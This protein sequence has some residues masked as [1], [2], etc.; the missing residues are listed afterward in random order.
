MNDLNAQQIV[1]LTLLV[2][3]ITSIATGITTVSL[4]ERA[5]EPVVQTINRVIEKTVERVVESDEDGENPVERIV[6]TVVV[7]NE[8]LTIKAIQKNSGKL[9]RIY[10]QS[11]DLKTF[12]G[13]GIV[14]SESGDVVADARNI[15]SGLEYVGEFS[16]GSHSL[17]IKFREVNNPFA[18][19]SAND[20]A[21]FSSASFGNSDGVQLAQSVIALSGQ[22][23]N[24]VTTGII[25]VIETA[26]VSETG[27]GSVMETNL[28]DTSVDSSKI[29]SGSMLLNL[30]GE[31]VGAKIN[32]D[33]TRNTAF[34]PSNWIKNFL[35]SQ[36]TTGE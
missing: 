8:D 33:P 7:N 12:A 23:N 21:T 30:K 6:E 29:L 35:A 15:V 2:S 13:L 34:I 24:V 32:G 1:L 25:T 20:V 31:I 17:S 3:F 22:N 18:L 16:S 11:G 4:L 36:A 9:V 26:D 28:F 5:P 27:D 10:S 14:V 19:L